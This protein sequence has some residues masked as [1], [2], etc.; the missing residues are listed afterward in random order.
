[1][2]LWVASES[3][4]AFSRGCQPTSPSPPSLPPRSMTAVTTR[5]TTAAASTQSSTGESRDWD[6]RAGAA[7]PSILSIRELP[8]V[9]QDDGE[10]DFRYD[11]EEPSAGGL[12]E[13]VAAREYG[14]PVGARQE[15]LAQQR[16]G[17]LERGRL[18]DLRREAR[19]GEERSQQDVSEH[20]AVARQERRQQQ[21]RRRDADCGQH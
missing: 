2:G 21:D 1:M 12:A 16:A 7:P 18:E 6:S 9:E 11:R 3:A 14:V 10:Q 17:L 20:V 4:A 15:V 5:K 8:A 13:R 19:K